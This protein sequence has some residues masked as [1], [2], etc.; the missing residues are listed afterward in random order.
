MPLAAVPVPGVQEEVPAADRSQLAHTERAHLG[1]LAGGRAE[2]Q[3]VRGEF[4]LVVVSSIL[5]PYSTYSFLIPLTLQK[6]IAHYTCSTVT[7]SSFLIHPTLQLLIPHSS[8]ANSSSSPS[9][10]SLSLPLIW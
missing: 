3:A 10:S 4:K 8:S 2:L 7:H 5:I 9:P 6:L 1:R